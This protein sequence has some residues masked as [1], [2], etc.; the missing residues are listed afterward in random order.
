MRLLSVLLLFLCSNTYA[1]KQVLLEKY[2]S[3]FCGVC[4]VGHLEAEALAE[5]YP[6]LILALHHS[7]VDGM[8]NEHSTEWKNFFA[9]PG[10]PMA[11]IDRTAPSGSPIPIQ[12]SNWEARI[13]EQLSQPEY[14]NIQLSGDY[15][16]FNREL[17]LDVDMYFTETPPEGELRVTLMVLEDSVI[18]AGFGYDQDNYYNEVEGHPL[19][20]LGHPMYF[21]PHNHVVRDMVDG[22]WGAS[23]IFPEEITIGQNYLHH[24]DYYVTWSWDQ[25]FIKFIVLVSLYEEDNP[26]KQQV[27]NA[28]EI[29]VSDLLA[30]DINDPLEEN[31]PLFVYPN[32]ARQAL[33]LQL[34]KGSYAIQLTDATG[35]VY[36]NQDWDRIAMNY[37]LETSN[38]PQGV[39][40]L[41][42]YTDQTR[43][44]TPVTIIR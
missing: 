15:D 28:R 38:Y 6:E 7:S 20:G 12:L 8:A 3:A 2:T 17:S 18:H 14:V 41:I 32:P 22:T 11:M 34:P 9:I 42:V 5:A 30:L 29:S 37:T 43:H 36:L 35:K 21:Y 40:Y 24:F 27:L 1:Q 4:P 13:Q 16:D 33:Q 10:A 39:Y 31:A 25:D 44:V 19:Y 26:Q 23:E